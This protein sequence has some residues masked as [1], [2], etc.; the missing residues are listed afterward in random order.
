[1]KTSS[2]PSSSLSQG[3]AFYHSNSGIDILSLFIK[4][5]KTV[6]AEM[7]VLPWI[8]T[9][10]V[11]G[12]LCTALAYTKW[13]WQPFF[14]WQ[15]F[16]KWDCWAFN[17][18][19]QLIVFPL[20]DCARWQVAIFEFLVSGVVVP[21][22]IPYFWTAFVFVAQRTHTVSFT[23]VEVEIAC[24]KPS[25]AEPT[26]CFVYASSSSSNFI[27]KCTTDNRQAVIVVSG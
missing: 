9:P 12:L 20:G 27:V 11:K 22:R 26:L 15:V 5:L 24:F 1:M 2:R 6:F 16:V 19:F 13:Q 18:Q 14:E 8:K 21:L 17:P 10:S 3:K 25:Y 7:D 23:K 4:S